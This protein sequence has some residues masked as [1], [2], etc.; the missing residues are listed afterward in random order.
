M[1]GSM[2]FA[3]DRTFRLSVRFRVA[4]FAVKLTDIDRD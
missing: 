4:G 3:K 1:S 2:N